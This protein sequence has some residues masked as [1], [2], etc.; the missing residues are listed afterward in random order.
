METTK[1]IVR[2]GAMR[3]H[4]IFTYSSEEC[5][6]HGDRVLVNTLRGQEIGVI[7]CQTDTE[8]EVKLD[9][10]TEDVQVIRLITPD[11]DI[12]L[13]R[14]IEL[15]RE[16]FERCRKIVQQMNIVMDLIRVEHIFG[17]E[18]LIVY[19]IAEGRIDFRDLVKL[20]ASEFQTRIEMRQIGV[21]DET[22]LLAD[23]GDCGMEVC[24][25]LYLN[26]MLPVSMKMAKLQKST[27][28]PNKIRGRCGRLKCCLRYEYDHYVEIQNNL[29]PI[30]VEV[31]TAIGD[32][33]VVAHE[34][35][36]KKVWVEMSDLGK[37]LF[38]PSVISI[39]SSVNAIK[40]SNLCCCMKDECDMCEELL[41]DE[42]DNKNEINIDTSSDT[43]FNG[44]K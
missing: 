4:G 38:C 19:Y 9:I 35:L 22:R 16:E 34:L 31:T 13:Q 43:E 20:L 42:I 12:E 28:D 36:A 10:E 11:D 18:R 39:K 30:G 29:P 41:A 32:G 17:G 7:L 25:N 27:L 26:D 8:T 40:N 6:R 14:I 44:K 21:R 33:K 23:F 37:K 2:Y 24:C 3:L 15:E 1:Y 5:L